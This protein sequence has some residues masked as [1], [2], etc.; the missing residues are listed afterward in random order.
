MKIQEMFCPRCGRPSDGLCAACRLEAMPWATI[1]PR[2]VL[3][4]CPS[5]RYVKEKGSW[6]ASSSNRN[7]LIETIVHSALRVEPEVRDVKLSIQSE[8]YSSNLT[9]CRVKVTGTIHGKPVES[10]MKLDILFKGE[11][12][13]RCSRMSGG[14]YEGVVQVRAMGRKCTQREKETIIDRAYEI[15]RTLTESGDNLSFIA[16]IDE[17]HKC[18]DIIVGTQQ[19]GRM[20]AED[21]VDILGGRMT[22]HPKLVG[23]KDGIP[24]YRVTYAVK[25]PYYQKGD[26]VEIDGRIVEIRDTTSRTASIFALDSGE[27]RVVR[28]DKHWRHIDNVHN[29]F[30]GVVAYQD[31]DFIGIINPQTGR[32]YEVRAVPWLNIAIGSQVRALI[33]KDRDS[34]IVVG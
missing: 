31:R 21:I 6:I 29:A 28:L 7:D 3:T 8:D 2:I 30:D 16:R 32:T 12:C 34:L 18:I 17:V 23:E 5:C 24:I 10:L 14:Y 25:L 19:L 22:T 33:D 11:L 15:E 1:E 4:Y 9:A 13:P 20:I 27:M 26:V